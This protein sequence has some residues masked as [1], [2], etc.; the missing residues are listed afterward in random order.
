MSETQ[1]IR[2][3]FLAPRI[4]L[5]H[6][7]AGAS[8]HVIVDTDDGDGRLRIH[9]S[10]PDRSQVYFELVAYPAVLDIE[11]VIAGQRTYLTDQDPSKT[12]V[13]MSRPTFGAI[14]G[15]TA[16]QVH[17]AFTDQDGRFDRLFSFV[18]FADAADPWGLRVVFDPRS[19]LNHEI[20]RR[21]EV[22]P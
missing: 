6:P 14:L 16:T 9:L 21:L 1:W 19:N 15:R 12:D 2:N 3:E 10:T 13:V 8:G 7:A 18:N 11:S 17:L 5:H 22:K 4:L 20:V